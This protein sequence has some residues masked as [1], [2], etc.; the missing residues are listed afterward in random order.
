MAN[1]RNTSML[2]V[3]SET[4]EGDFQINPVSLALSV[5]QRVNHNLIIQASIELVIS[6]LVLFCMISLHDLII[7]HRI[8]R[9]REY[10][11]SFLYRWAD[12]DSFPLT[13]RIL[14]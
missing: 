9:S 12:I 8:G 1:S 2:S 7:L 11:A 14:A 4:W 10:S 3:S 13:R 6:L 5:E